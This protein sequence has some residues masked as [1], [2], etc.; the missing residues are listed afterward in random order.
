MHRSA[1]DWKRI[2]N[3]IERAMET[4]STSLSGIA[5]HA[6]AIVKRGMV[7]AYPTDT[8]YALGVD[9][10]N[11]DAV[12][13]L[14]KLKGRDGTK[15]ISI[16]VA[17]IEILESLAVLSNSARRVASAF[18]PG[19]LTIVLPAK[20]PFSAPILNERGFVGI[21]IPDNC[22]CSEFLRAVGAP[23]TA[24]SANPSGV[25]PALQPDDF[26]HFGLDFTAGIALLVDGRRTHLSAPSTVIRVDGSDV[27]LIREGAI[28]FEAILAVAR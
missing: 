1:R 19:A 26:S 25:A 18:L 7:V 15:P 11:K 8:T 9:A 2:D 28:P 27:S 10:L 17:N 5:P 12:A 4:L 24:T 21:R 14:I 16:C 13:R 20:V 3:H 23:V 22:F 6:A